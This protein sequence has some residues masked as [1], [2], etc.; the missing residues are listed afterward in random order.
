[1][2]TLRRMAWQSWPRPIDSESPSPD[3]PIMIRSPLAA[4]APVATAGMRPCTLL[5]PCASRR[6]YAGVFD[7]QPMPDSFA[8]LY[9]EIDR[10]QNAWMMAAVIESWP[11]PA[12]RVVI[13]PS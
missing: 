8:T 4:F 5:K 2:F 1:M 13:E 6:K 3:T 7:E 9:G 12:Q 11:Q 10:S